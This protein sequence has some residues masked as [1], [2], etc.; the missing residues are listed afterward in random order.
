MTSGR[1]KTWPLEPPLPSLSQ[2]WI[3]MT[4]LE[5]RGKRHRSPEFTGQAMTRP[6]LLPDTH[7]HRSGLD[8]RP[9]TRLCL[10]YFVLIKTRLRSELASHSK[11]PRNSAG[12]LERRD[13]S[14]TPGQ[15]GRVLANRI[16]GVPVSGAGTQIFQAPPSLAF[17]RYRGP[18]TPCPR[19]IGQDLQQKRTD[20]AD[21]VPGD[22]EMS[23]RQANTRTRA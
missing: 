5:R 20:H 3:A 1:S 7:K 14:T 2:P 9:I 11:Q 22:L 17:E 6:S 10:D 19:V 12:C 18:W 4:G 16:N 23:R 13:F 15:A 8:P 21:R